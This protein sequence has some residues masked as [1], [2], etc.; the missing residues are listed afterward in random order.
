VIGLGLLVGHLIGDY[1]LQDDWQAANK[2]N[3]WPG[4]QPQDSKNLYMQ[5]GGVRQGDKNTLEFAAWWLMRN[6]WW[7][8]HL[9]CTIHCTLYTL[10]VWFCS[11]W[12]MP[13]WG[14]AVCWLA[15]WPIDRW[16]LARHFMR[17]TNH[18]KFATGPLSPWSIIVVDNAIHL[19]TLFV[20]GLIAGK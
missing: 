12:W 6:D 3:P 15:H 17:W 1:I 4:W 9:A 10:A 19:A 11:F 20:I 8:G 2:T 13:L 5:D 18:E 14:L 16:R 7:K